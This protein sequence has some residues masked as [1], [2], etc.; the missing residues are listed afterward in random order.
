MVTLLLYWCII[1]SPLVFY[2]Y[3]H[4]Q[5]TNKDYTFLRNGD[6]TAA[7]LVYDLVSTSGRTV[8]GLGFAFLK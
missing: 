4:K 5:T 7:V 1:W 2:K 8:A 3:K 6:Y